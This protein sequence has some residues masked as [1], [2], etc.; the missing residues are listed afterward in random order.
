MG[1]GEELHG[2]NLRSVQ[3]NGLWSKDKEWAGEAVL[4]GLVYDIMLHHYGTCDIYWE[5]SDVVYVTIQATVICNK[6]MMTPALRAVNHVM[7]GA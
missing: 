7:A 5:F 4:K 3:L 1:P 6:Q 2:A